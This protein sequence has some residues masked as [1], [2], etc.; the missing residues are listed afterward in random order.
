MRL[1]ELQEFFSC[2]SPRGA[3]G[4]LTISEDDK[5]VYIDAQVPGARSEDIEVTV[6]R[7][8]SRLKISAKANHVR[9]EN[10]HYHSKGSERFYYEIPFTNMI[11][12]REK[13]EA[14]CK[15]GI[16]TIELTKIRAP[17]PLKIEV[18]VA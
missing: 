15:D 8:N 2:C 12:L 16:L 10:A 7:E 3:T 5:K 18:K 6:D 14:S 13:I 1:N 9:R 17:E 11:D 4:G